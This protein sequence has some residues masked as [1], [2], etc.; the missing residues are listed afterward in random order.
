MLWGL[1]MQTPL[2]PHPTYQTYLRSEL[3]QRSQTDPHYSLRHF[4]KSIGISPGMLS[5]V[6]SGRRRLSLEN[7]V[8][9]SKQL[10]L[11]PIES[12]KFLQSV[13][14]SHIRKEDSQVAPSLTS[15]N[16]LQPLPKDIFQAIADW[17]HYAIL[18]MT[19]LNRKIITPRAI[20]RELGCSYVE[21]VD[22]IERLKHLGLLQVV[23]GKLVKSARHFT[24]GSDYPSNAMK[25]MH[26]QLLEKAKLSLVRD[27]LSRRDCTSMTMAI[28]SAKLPE[29][30]KRIAEFRRSLCALLEEGPRDR[31][32]A[33]TVNLF[34]LSHE[35][36][37]A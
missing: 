27:E 11:S 37:E 2:L 3:V 33:M 18:E 32:Y 1:Q 28:N 36:G 21:A 22:A 5:S 29:A 24:S 19:F 26:L 7:A 13:V 16:E 35:G 34:P 6:L 9:I 15:T 10:D 8:R 20:A 14:E 25:R 23:K 4:A 31:I 17:Y 12:R 30:K